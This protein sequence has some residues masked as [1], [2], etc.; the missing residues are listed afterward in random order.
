[1]KEISDQ[2]QIGSFLIVCSQVTSPL[3]TLDSVF[4]YYHLFLRRGT[5]ILR[6][7]PFPFQTRICLLLEHGAQKSHT[8][9]DPG[10]GPGGQDPPLLGDP[11]TS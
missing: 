10:G 4:D 6:V 2:Y 7:C 11:Q 1:M 5:I 3:H 8:G 9:A